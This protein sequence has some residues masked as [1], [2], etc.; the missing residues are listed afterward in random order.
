MAALRL[1]VGVGGLRGEG[2]GFGFARRRRD[3]SGIAQDRGF[4][5]GDMR[6]CLEIR[7][8]GLSVRT[9]KHVLAESARV[10]GQGIGYRV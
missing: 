8:V 4:E 10:K 9:R 2:A 1:D 3:S 6:E 7:G 5:G